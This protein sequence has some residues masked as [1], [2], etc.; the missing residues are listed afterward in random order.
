MNDRAGLLAWIFPPVVEGRGAVGLLLLRLVAGA[1][2]LVH[3]SGKIQ[4]P[5]SWMPPEAPIPGF[6]QALA[7]VA[8][9][10]GGGLGW[11]AGFL[12]PLASLGV[13]AT[14]TV[15]IFFHVGRGDPFVGAGGPSFELAFIYWCI[16][17]LML[18][19]GPGRFSLDAQLF[20]RRE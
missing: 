3:G 10:F 4:T 15:A 8:E 6:L 13:L 12:T 18:L 11:V 7:A 2:F 16:A 20:R 17:L 14:M 19:I 1:A 9:F 5:F